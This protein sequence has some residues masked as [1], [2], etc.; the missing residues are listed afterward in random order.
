MKSVT[1]GSGL[2]V[3]A[4]SVPE[5]DEWYWLKRADYEYVFTLNSL[6][7]AGIEISQLEWTDANNISGGFD[8]TLAHLQTWIEGYINGT[9]GLEF[10]NNLV[11][12]SPLITAVASGGPGAIP[13]LLLGHVFNALILGVVEKLT[14]DKTL[15]DELVDVSGPDMPDTLHITINNES[16]DNQDVLWKVDTTP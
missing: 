15:N 4:F 9:V 14:G 3:P 10:I 2:P 13:A 1:V 12:M 5:S 8:I 7:S 16:T 11:D 6:K